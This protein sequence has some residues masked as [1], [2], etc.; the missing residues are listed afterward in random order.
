MTDLTPQL[1][2]LLSSSG[3]Q[4]TSTPSLNFERLDSFLEEAY[5]IVC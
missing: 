5:R 2:Q 4:V 3:S 1:N